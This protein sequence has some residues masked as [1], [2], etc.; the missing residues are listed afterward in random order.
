MSDVQKLILV[1]VKFF[2]SIVYLIYNSYIQ[3]VLIHSN[4]TCED[5]SMSFCI[6]HMLFFWILNFSVNFD[7]Q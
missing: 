2:V 4:K 5:I 1:I 6:W 7:I 3:K